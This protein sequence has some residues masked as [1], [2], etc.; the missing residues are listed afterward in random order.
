[1]LYL[2]V[3]Y[4]VVFTSGSTSLNSIFVI[5]IVGVKLFYWAR[6]IIN[7]VVV[8]MYLGIFEANVR[9]CYYIYDWF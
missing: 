4:V 9:P 6:I 2:C 8:E 5:I 1:M 3:V 7:F